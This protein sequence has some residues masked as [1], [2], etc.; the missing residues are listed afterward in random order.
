LKDV[1][2]RGVR[3]GG[4]GCVLLEEEPWAV[5][6]IAMDGVT[7]GLIRLG[8]MLDARCVAVVFMMDDFVVVDVV[9]RW[10]ARHLARL[11]MVVAVAAIPTAVPTTVVFVSKE[12]GEKMTWTLE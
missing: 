2:R 4:H 7:G 1:D 10:S 9:A 12:N 3:L 11:G 5:L 6:E 8:I